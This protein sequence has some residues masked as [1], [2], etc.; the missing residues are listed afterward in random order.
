MPKPEKEAAVQEIREMLSKSQAVVLANYR[1]LNVAAMT[2]LRRKLGE[3]GAEFKVVKNTLAR[4]ASRE[5]GLAGLEQYLEGPT[6]IAFA[7]GDPVA[8]AK[9]ISEFTREHKEMEIKGGALQGKIIGPDDVRSLAE[10]P[11][12]EVM[13]GRVAATMAAP[14]SGLARALAGTIRNLAYAIDAVKR[15]KE[16]QGAAA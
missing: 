2:E 7:S 5:V 4:I 1:G 10:L 6:A 9:V 16:E 8:P 13:L 12:R 11:S 3:A 15:Q 14:I